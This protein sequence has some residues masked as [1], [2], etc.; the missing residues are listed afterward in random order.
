[1]RSFVITTTLLTSVFVLPLA[2][3]AK[4]AEYCKCPVLKVKDLKDL[5]ESGQTYDR[6]RGYI[7]Y[8]KRKV[9]KKARE[10]IASIAPQHA[11]RTKAGTG[12]WQYIVRDRAGLEIHQLGLEKF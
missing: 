10:R 7:V 11:T 5:Y 4:A 2:S 1:M 8:T 12:V 3:L 6:Y 9:T